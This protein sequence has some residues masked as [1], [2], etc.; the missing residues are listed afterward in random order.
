MPKVSSFFGVVVYFYQEPSHPEPHFH[1]R[2][3][4]QY[5][6]VSLEH[7]EVLAG[8]VGRGGFDVTA[9]KRVRKWGL[10][11]HDELKASWALFNE[12]GEAQPVQPL[13]KTKR[14]PGS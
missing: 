5:I 4:G 13:G 8:S 10:L 14:N 3:A 2:H 12:T 9:W 7:M 6:S 1:A 11:Y